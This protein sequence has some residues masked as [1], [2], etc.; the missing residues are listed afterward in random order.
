MNLKQMIGAAIRRDPDLLPA[1]TESLRQKI[2]QKEDGALSS[3]IQ[4][5][6]ALEPII[7]EAVER[8]PSRIA[9]LGLKSTHLLAGLTME[10]S[11][12]NKKLVEIARNQIVGIVFVDVEG[13][14]RY[15]ADN[16]DDAAIEMI[17]KVARLAK[18]ASRVG[19]GEVVKSLGDGYLLAFPSASQAVRAA[20]ALRDLSVE[21]RE[22][23]PMF[24]ARLQIAVHAGE[25]LVEQDDLLGHDVNLTARLL[26]HCDGDEVI[27]SEAA[28]ELA[29]QRLR[30]VK[31]GRRRKVKIRG[32]TSR[33][34]VYSANPTSKVRRALGGSVG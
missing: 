5:A 2:W 22:R 25:P 8:K 10:D 17:G 4:A 7:A 21:L 34:I 19:K 31:F 6:E 24:Q 3:A 28:Q 33:V 14:T 11:A 1:I 29:G 13:F 12:S 30:N 32:L 27:V 26:D 15:T 23:D 18:K 9:R 16:G 20:V